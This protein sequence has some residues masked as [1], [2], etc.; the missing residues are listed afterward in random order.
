[1]A[2]HTNEWDKIT[3]PL[4][5]RKALDVFIII[6]SGFL[7]APLMYCVQVESSK[8]EEGKAGEKEG[9]VS[10]VVSGICI[11]GSSQANQP[12]RALPTSSQGDL[13]SMD[14]GI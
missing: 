1:M 3:F 4:G 9:G 12:L 5:S 2:E 10:G 8:G 7:E 6:G 11:P 13:A 14:Y